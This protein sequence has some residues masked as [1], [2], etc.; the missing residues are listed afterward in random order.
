MTEAN[1]DSS[2]STVPACTSPDKHMKMKSLWK[3]IVYCMCT[4]PY[5]TAILWKLVPVM[6]SLWKLVPVQIICTSLYQYQS[7]AIFYSNFTA[8]PLYTV[9]VLQ[10]TSLSLMNPL[11]KYH[12]QMSKLQRSKKG[13][14]NKT[15]WMK[16]TTYC[17]ISRPEPNWCGQMHMWIVRTT[18]LIINTC[19]WLVSFW[20]F[21][22]YILAPLPIGF[23]VFLVHLA[24]IP[25]TGTGINPARSFAAAV[26]YNHDKPWDDQVSSLMSNLLAS[27]CLWLRTKFVHN[28]LSLLC[29]LVDLFAKFSGLLC[30][31]LCKICHFCGL[32]C[33]NVIVCW[34]I[35]VL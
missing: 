16:S 25:I 9:C 19:E 23:S 33:K 3:P 7:N 15:Q 11:W 35:C 26:I 31:L 29:T 4:M 20:N 18:W 17:L 5:F 12:F 32:I 6:K 2:C 27:V 13:R 24:T 30:Q 21:L 28:Y 10:W 22:L 14:T 34:F 8:S 1:N